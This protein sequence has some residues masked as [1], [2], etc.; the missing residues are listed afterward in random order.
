VPKLQREDVPDGFLDRD[1]GVN[2]VQNRKNGGTRWVPLNRTLTEV[3]GHTTLHLRGPFAFCKP[4]GTLY[5]SIKKAFQAA[6]RRAGL[7]DFRFHDLRHDLASW[8]TMEGCNGFTL[9]ELMGHKT[10][11]MTM[12]YVHPSHQVERQVVAMLDESVRPGDRGAEQ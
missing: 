4:D 10:T 9:M 5:G 12:R 8:L 11:A 7:S 2:I 3:L 1:L 6:V